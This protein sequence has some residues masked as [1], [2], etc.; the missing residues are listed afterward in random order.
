PRFAPFSSSLHEVSKPQLASSAFQIKSAR[1][2]SKRALVGRFGERP[3]L[4][5][6]DP[7]LLSNGPRVAPLIQTRL[8]FGDKCSVR[9]ESDSRRLFANKQVHCSKKKQNFFLNCAAR[10]GPVKNVSAL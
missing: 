6:R 10:K 1:T 3:T 7:T 5:F 8:V 2:L 4:R 9:M